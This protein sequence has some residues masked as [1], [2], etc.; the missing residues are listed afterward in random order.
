[1]NVL[2]YGATGMVGQGV[3]SEAL[4][5]ERVKRVQI[6]GRSSAGVS[7]PKLDEVLL[8]DL[9]DPTPLEP[10]LAGFD[11]C[12]FCL[13][14]SAAGLDEAS[15][16]RINHDI[17]LAHAQLLARLNPTMCFIYV[18][19]AG[20]GSA[21]AMWARVKRSTEQALLALPFRAAYMLRPGV[22]QPLHGARSKTA[23]Y[24]AFYTVAGPLLTLARRLFP[25]Q[26]VSTEEVG[27]AMLKLA[28]YG[29]PAPIL[30]PA[31]IRA[32]VGPPDKR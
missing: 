23:L 30:E 6:V 29:A 31:D 24:H 15:Y 21:S 3:L 28:Q 16:R 5:D 10:R 32:L 20:T 22:I 25:N 14:A 1:M 9:L 12:F 11:A 26:V 2:I 17:P 19:G 13:R 4:G 8:A 7:H 27:L 18:S